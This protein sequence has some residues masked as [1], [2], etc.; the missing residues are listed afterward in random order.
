MIKGWIDTK[1]SVN[2]EVYGVLRP[3]LC[4]LN[5]REVTW[6]LEENVLLHVIWDKSDMLKATA[7]TIC[8]GEEWLK[9]RS[10]P[11]WLLLRGLTRFNAMAKEKCRNEN[12]NLYRIF[13]N[14]I[15]SEKVISV[16]SLISCCSLCV[17]IDCKW[18]KR[19]WFNR[20]V[21]IGSSTIFKA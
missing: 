3:R 2:L 11:I 7:Q 10:S 1:G 8:W 21:L 6:T 4:H 18:T 16:T 5:R 17:N 13:I 12:Y 15:E 14:A 9:V 19:I 20:Q